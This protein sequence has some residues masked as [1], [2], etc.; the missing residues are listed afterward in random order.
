MVDDQYVEFKNTVTLHA[1][2]YN[3]ILQND[4]QHAQCQSTKNCP[5]DSFQNVI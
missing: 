1:Y 4:A 2:A 3:E 5:H